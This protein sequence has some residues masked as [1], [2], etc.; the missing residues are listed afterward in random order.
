MENSTGMVMLQ[1]VRVYSVKKYPCKIEGKDSECIMF[2]AHFLKPN[3]Q[4]AN[5]KACCKVWPENVPAIDRL[6]LKDGAVVNIMAELDQCKSRDGK[7]D[8][9]FVVRHMS[10]AKTEQDKNDAKPQS[11]NEGKTTQAEPEDPRKSAKFME[12]AMMLTAGFSAMS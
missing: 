7:D 11:S 10:Y 9:L 3:K 12:T 1:N 6:H 8:F 5:P 4:G 2:F